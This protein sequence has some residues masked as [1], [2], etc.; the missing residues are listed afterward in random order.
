MLAEAMQGRN[1]LVVAAGDL[2]HVGPAFDGSPVRADG[3]AKLRRAD[4]AIL[5]DMSEGAPKD[6]SGS[7]RRSMTATTSAACLRFTCRSACSGERRARSSPTTNALRTSR[8]V[9]G[10]GR[11]GCSGGKSRRETGVGI[12]S[13]ALNPCQRLPPPAR[14]SNRVLPL[15]GLQAAPSSSPYIPTSTL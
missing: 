10:V 12:L 1:D 6:F 14:A 7:L 15:G 3:Q 11:R 2:A 8:T 13:R 5:G 4:E 9:V